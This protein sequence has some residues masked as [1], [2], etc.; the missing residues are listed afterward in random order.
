M[1]LIGLLSTT[2]VM[3]VRADPVVVDS[4]KGLVDAARSASPGTVIQLKPGV[5]PGGIY[6]QGLRGTADRPIV[7][8]SLRKEPG[9]V[10]FS[11]DKGG[12][13]AIQLSACHHVTLRNLTVT[14]FPYNGI[15]ADDGGLDTRAVGLR[16][17]H[18]VIEDTG[19]RGNHDG[20]KLSGLRDFVVTDC[21]F[22]G[23]GGSGIDMV[24][25]HEGVIKKS[26]LEGRSGFSQASGIQMKG[27]TSQI[28][29]LQNTFLHAGQ[30]SLNLGGSTGLAYFRP[31]DAAWEA[32]DIEVA[33]N[34]FVGS[35]APIAWVGIDQGHVHHNTLY[36]PEKWVARILQENTQERFGRCRNGRFEH[37]LIVF[38]RRVRV[39]VNVGPNTQPGTF[40]FQGNAWFDLENPRRMLKLP[41]E[42]KGGV[43]GVDP[44]LSGIETGELKIGSRDPRLKGV[45]AD[46]YR[47][48]P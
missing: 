28:R 20:L 25:C 34:R 8:E 18:L 45:G 22:R 38:D 9:S 33:G 21:I 44:E 5:Y 35:V 48:S 29:V 11:A 39:S 27:G 41:V 19:P 12:N 13:T 46:A 17:E 14:G 30:R 31:P 32:R 36:L 3:P 23:W 4:K 37:N 40:L 2:W 10:V 43:A 15:N 42:E 7:I 24:G 16:F 47:P 6:L 1:A 26:R